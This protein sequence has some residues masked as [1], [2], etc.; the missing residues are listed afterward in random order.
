[1]AF[2]WYRVGTSGDGRPA[3]VKA[4]VPETDLRR[5]I[6]T[7]Q[8]RINSLDDDGGIELRF[9]PDEKFENYFYISMPVYSDPDFN[10]LQAGEWQRF[11]YGL[12]NAGKK[13]NPDPSKIRY[14]SIYLA[15]NGK[16][17]LLFDISNLELTP[18]THSPVLSYTFDDGYDD[19]LLA[20]D[21]LKQYGQTA[22][23]YIIPKAVGQPGYMSLAQLRGLAQDG[24]G[25]SAHDVTPFTQL[26]PID[27]RAEIDAIY[28]FF[29][30]AGL[31]DGMRHI[32][33][34]EGAQNRSYVLPEVRAAYDTARV[35]GGGMETLPPGDPALLRTFNVLNTTP[36]S[37]IKEQVALA[38]ENNQWLLLM[39][40]YLHDAQHPSDSPISYD[41]DKFRDVVKMVAEEGIAVLPVNKVWEDLAPRQKVAARQQSRAS[42]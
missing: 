21:I 38:K 18:T 15:D 39:F 3:L 19:V 25:L 40:H 37:E 4:E 11:S 30:Q 2:P 8:C 41:I 10:I 29:R 36:V 14:V 20:A 33:Y 5:A 17:P 31:E 27:L 34:P 26:T 24:W 28:S 22:T 23:A 16:A 1:D 32:A 6:I 12:G 13:G 42:Q 7:F 9:S 35:A